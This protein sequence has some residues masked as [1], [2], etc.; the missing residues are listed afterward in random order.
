MKDCNKIH[1]LLSLYMEEELSP[2]DQGRVD[3]HLKDCSDARKELE[4]YRALRKASRALPE[5]QAPADLHEKIM[6][7]VT[8]K[9]RSLPS[10]RPIWA[11]PAW[12]L[13]AAACVALFFLIQ[14]PDLFKFSKPQTTS[15]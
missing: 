1:P 7:R 14:N 4:D 5:P 3:R 8:G 12:G 6:G 9:L 10:R 2:S 15:L 11:N 13:A